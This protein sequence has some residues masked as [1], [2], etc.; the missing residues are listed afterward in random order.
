MLLRPSLLAIAVFA[1]I[2][3]H[4]DDNAPLTPDTADANS[5]ET[6][7]VIGQG[8]TRQVQRITPDDVKVLPPGT[9]PL[10]VL[11]VMPGVHFESSDAFGNYEWSTR[12]SLRGFNQNRIGFT[13]DGVPLGDMSYG[14]NNG[15]HISRALIAEN[16]GQIELAQG[17][18]ALGMASTNDLGGGIQFHSSDPTSDYGVHLAQTFGS[19]S[20]T[21]TFARIDTGDHDGFMMYLS[22]AYADTDKWK[23][24]GDQQQTAFNLKATYDFGGNRI[25]A[26]VSS[27]DR[28]EV[29]YAD[30]SLVDT[31]IAGWD[32]DNFAP[33]WNAAVAAGNCVFGLPGCALPAVNG[34]NTP[35]DANDNLD[36]AYYLGRGVRKDHLVNV[37]GDFVFDGGWTL[38][39]QVYHHDDRGQGHWFSPYYQSSPTVPV[40]IRTTEYGIDRA[41]VIAYVGYDFG[42]NHLE[43]GFWGED[44]S[45]HLQRNYYFIDGPVDDSGFLRNPDLRVFYQHFDTTTRQFYVQ[46][47]IRLLDNRL[48]IDAGFKSP[49][50]KTEATSLIG[51]RAYGTLEADKTFLPQVGASYKLSEHEEL[52]GSYA[53][54][55]AAFQAG[56]AGPFS[57]SETSFAALDN[58]K[59]LKPEE[60]KTFEGGVRSSHADFEASAALYSVKFDNRLLAISQCAGIVGCPTGFAN[61]G[62]VSSRGAEFTFI[63]KPLENLRWFNSLSLNH[64]K[65]DANY[66][67][68][69]TLVP[70]DGKTQVDSPKTMFSSALEWHQGPLD[71]RLQAKYEGKRYYTYLN[72]AAV[73]GFWLFDA[74]AGYDLGNVW[75]LRDLTARVNITNLANKR[76]FGTIGSNGFLVSDPT[77]QYYTLQAGAPRQ[78]FITVDAK[79]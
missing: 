67:N 36:A 74:S 75:M 6:I 18:G 38:H 19:D 59:G 66:M 31:R 73:P 52:F 54:N 51:T 49:D 71:A 33:D 58:G 30:L 28:D 17:I 48:T 61:V 26:L 79:F 41:G 72:D 60:S 40:A 46:D 4:A 2:N 32:F 25:S 42:F 65:Y 24:Y 53:Q 68:G 14:N 10:K 20:T 8:E 12:I 29:D 77:G 22:G 57:A 9:S 47:T 43:G 13:L 34:P 21:R 7:S 45:H 56:V 55:I 70:V 11:D 50:A 78:A 76:Y 3:A 64:A 23:G 37:A 69:D 39:A 63:W 5:L 62:S 16:L 1:A 35:N 15:L 44:S 27:S